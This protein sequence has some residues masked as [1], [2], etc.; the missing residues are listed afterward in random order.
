MP[1]STV[2]K[3]HLRAD[4]SSAVR[5][6][7]ATSI[8]SI[9]REIP[10]RLQ[11]ALPLVFAENGLMVMGIVDIDKV[12]LFNTGAGLKYTDMTAEA[13]HLKRPGA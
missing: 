8:L 3:K 6:F 10:P 4:T 13:M 2:E 1:Q 7:T 5:I 12:V 9:R 11:L